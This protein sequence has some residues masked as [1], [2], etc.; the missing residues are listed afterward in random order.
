MIL[1]LRSYEI[2]NKYYIDHYWVVDLQ[3]NKSYKL[4]LGLVTVL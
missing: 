3:I 2:A 4:L 1:L